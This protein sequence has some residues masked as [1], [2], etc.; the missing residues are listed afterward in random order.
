MSLTTP[1]NNFFS[2]CFKLLVI[3]VLFL[4]TTTACHAGQSGQCY[5]PNTG[6][7]GMYICVKNPPPPKGY[8][9]PEGGTT[10]C[11]NDAD[12]NHG[13]CN[14]D[15]LKQGQCVP[16]PGPADGS[17]NHVCKSNGD[18]VYGCSLVNQ[19]CTLGGPGIACN[20]ASDCSRRCDNTGKCV[21][22]ADGDLCTSDSECGARCTSDGKCVLHNPSGSPCDLSATTNACPLR[23]KP[24][25]ACSA[26]GN[27]HKC[28]GEADCADYR[29]TPEGSCTEGGSGSACDPAAEKNTC[30]KKICVK[31]SCQLATPQNPVGPSCATSADCTKQYF[32]CSSGKCTAKTGT[33]TSTC[34]ADKDCLL[35]TCSGTTCMPG[36]LGGKRCSDSRSCATPTK[37]TAAPAY[38]LNTKL[39]SEDQQIEAAKK[40]A[41]LDSNAPVYKYGP[42]DAKVKV[43]IFSDL[44]CGMCARGFKIWT[45]AA[46]QKYPD[47]LF[48]FRDRPLL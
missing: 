44:T 5:F 4:S 24:D 6:S 45:N 13:E 33:G 41:Q 46:L 9:L 40:L 48:R 35:P 32:I 12:C 17:E 37:P 25:G 18:C 11:Q 27:G 30:P 16:A 7:G 8:A 34:G 2:L 19:S 43:D 1:K 23:C 26:D 22:D 3:L 47:V 14:E 10:I 39:L 28:S 36:V 15:P 38:G 29:C 31:G 21:Q 20:S 42:V